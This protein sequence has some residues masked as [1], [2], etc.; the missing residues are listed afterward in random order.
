MAVTRL[1]DSEGRLAAV[2]VVVRDRPGI[3]PPTLACALGWSVQLAWQ[4]VYHLHERGI[5]EIRLDGLAMRLYAATP[6]GPSGS[7]RGPSS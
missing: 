6:D 7:D 4:A 2:L 1:E 3:D 5:V